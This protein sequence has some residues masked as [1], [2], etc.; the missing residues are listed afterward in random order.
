MWKEQPMSKFVKVRTELRDLALIKRALDDLQ[1]TYVENA[2]YTHGF[3]GH[4]EQAPLVVKHRN[5]TYALSPAADGTYQVLGD[6][7]LMPMIKQ[8]LDKVQQR[9]AYHKVLR[10][11]ESAG[12][13][14]VEEQTG[15]DNVI[16]M[17]V[18]RWS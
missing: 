13:A 3:S 10:E 1:L 6:D 9:Y 11:V 17:T 7:M 8:T 15:K 4:K 12:F 5:V 14:L 2:Q 18:R 16:R